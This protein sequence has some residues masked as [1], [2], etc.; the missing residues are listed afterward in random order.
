MFKML[1]IPRMKGNLKNKVRLF[2][3]QKNNRNGKGNSKNNAYGE[4]IVYF[5]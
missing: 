1:Y 3:K 4:S 5:K 2:I